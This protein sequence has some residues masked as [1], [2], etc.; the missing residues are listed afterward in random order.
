MKFHKIP[1]LLTLI[2]LSVLLLTGCPD[3]RAGFAESSGMTG[4]RPSLQ[5]VLEMSVHKSHI[6]KTGRAEADKARFDRHMVYQTYLPNV[7]LE[8][9]FRS[10]DQR[11][12]FHVDPIALPFPEQQGLQVAVPPITLQERNTFR[13]SLEVTQVLFT[14]FKVPRMGQAAYHGEQAALRKVE[15]DKQELIMEVAEA[16]DQLVLVEQSL[17]VI[18][19]AD[20]RLREERRV[21]DRAFEEG[22]IP[23]YDLTRL[24]IARNDLER[25]RIR[26]EGD[27]E[28]AARNLEHL[29]GISWKR[30]LE[31]GSDN[32][33][34]Y[35]SG[36]T[37]EPASVNDTGSASHAG[38]ELIGV[39]PGGMASRVRPEV[40]ALREAGKAADY[41]YRA[42]RADYFPQAYAFLRQELYEDD[43]SVLEPARVMGIGLRWELFDGFNRSRRIQKSERDRVIARE[44][45]EEVTS[46]VELDRRQ[47]EVRLSVAE[48]QLDV[49]RESLTDAKTSLQLSTQ[50]YRLGLAPVSEKLDAENGLQRAELEWQQAVF[51]QRRAA[52]ELIRAQG[53]M[54]IKTIANL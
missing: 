32:H 38:L 41:M 13:A 42:Q 36:S 5:E 53:H 30:F 3:A 28:L 17:K 25:E 23:A 20:N 18:A 10:L 2:L 8:S 24:R 22:L 47:A 48:K 9:S 49:A 46:L 34:G 29:S 7:T 16:Y 50:R 37:S 31:T 52:M 33:A 27:R 39:A 51:E 14:G 35:H 40:E 15:A 4:P 26:R 11:I 43:L 54:D 6:L 19:R 12:R 44:R 21:A 1:C 45:L